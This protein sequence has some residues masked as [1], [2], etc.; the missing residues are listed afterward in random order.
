M[1]VNF[2]TIL[3][4]GSVPSN[5]EEGSWI[6]PKRLMSNGLAR[7]MLP[8]EV[9]FNATELQRLSVNSKMRITV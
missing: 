4:E 8:C 9:P 3:L 5:S 1:S 2:S 7:G 6:M